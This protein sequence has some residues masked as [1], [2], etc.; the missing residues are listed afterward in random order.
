MSKGILLVEGNDDQHVVWSLC[1]A[2]DLPE[3]FAVEEKGGK[4]PL[5]AGLPGYLKNPARYPQVGVLLDADV[6]LA[7]RWESITQ[8]LRAAGFSLPPN[9]PGDGLV[10]NHPSGNGPRVGVW[11]MPNNHLPG[12]LEDF[13]RVLIPDDD[14]LAPEAERALQVI[15]GKGLQRY[16]AQSRPKAFI[17]TWLAWQEEPG[18]PMGLAI[19]KRY[20]DPNSPQADA[21]V[22]WL[23]QLF[24]DG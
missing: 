17:H 13:V 14:A 16:A 21:F 8:R 23:R 4:D 19:T 1:K 5:L 10:L 12:M 7:A 6:D 22:A 20:L 15:E 24:L 9:P 11:L 3:D 2:Y 18:K